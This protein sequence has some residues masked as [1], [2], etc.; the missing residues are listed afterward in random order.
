[1]LI[2][3]TTTLHTVV[4]HE[5]SKAEATGADIGKTEYTLCS[6]EIELNSVITSNKTIIITDRKSVV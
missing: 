1:M 5:E 4:R 3:V 6:N 2:T